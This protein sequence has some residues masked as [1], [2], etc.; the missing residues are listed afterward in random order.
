L[1]IET[2]R[3]TERVW[4]SGRL[5]QDPLNG[6]NIMGP[7]RCARGLAAYLA[8]SA[9]LGFMSVFC[10]AA[11]AVVIAPVVVEISPTRR[12]A[13][14]TVSNSD[15]SPISFQV[16]VLSWRQ[17]AGVDQYE[18]SNQLIV[19]P[20]IAEIAAGGSQ[21]FRVT[22]RLPPAPQEAAFRLILEDV[23]QLAAPA[24]AADAMQVV[25]RVNHNL[26]VFF[27][28]ALAP[29]AEPSIT[30]C[31]VVP[32]PGRGCVRVENAGNQHLVVKSLAL[33]RSAW[34]QQLPLSARVLAGSW[35]Q[36]EFDLPVQVNGS[37]QVMA[38]TSAGPVSAS[39]PAN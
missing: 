35:K 38:D 13:S 9:A 2:L 25:L 15:D 26:P 7:S 16:Q 30:A 14:L 29:R 24:G 19:V 34:R 23:T 12:V 8:S 31:A 33:T 28:A 39:L 1:S 10:A 17:V 27:A 4:Q 11:N 6:A 36:W 18:E 20:P 5:V 37:L 21:I 22:T 32:Q 3:A